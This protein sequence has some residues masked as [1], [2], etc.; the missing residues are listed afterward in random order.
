M[1]VYVEIKDASKIA[2]LTYLGHVQQ[3]FKVPR[4]RKDNLL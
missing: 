4:F 2:S 3:I 1:S